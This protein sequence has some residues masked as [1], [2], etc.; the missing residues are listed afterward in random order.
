MAPLIDNRH[1]IRKRSEEAFIAFNEAL[2]FKYV[3]P[4]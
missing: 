3:F 1:M 2:K 4:C